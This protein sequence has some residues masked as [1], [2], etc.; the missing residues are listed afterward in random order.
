MSFDFQHAKQLDSSVLTTFLQK[1]IHLSLLNNFSPKETL[2]LSGDIFCCH[3][4]EWGAVNGITD[5][6]QDSSTTTE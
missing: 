2:A 1:M 4:W 5:K 3:N 6:S